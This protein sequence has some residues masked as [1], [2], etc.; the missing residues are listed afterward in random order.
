MMRCR[1]L[2]IVLIVIVCGSIAGWLIGLEI[3]PRISSHVVNSEVSRTTRVARTS[4]EGSSKPR[5]VMLKKI[6]GNQASWVYYQTYLATLPAEVISSHNKRVLFAG[7]K[8]AGVGEHCFEKMLYLDIAFAAQ[9]APKNILEYLVKGATP[10]TKDLVAGALFD[11]WAVNNPSEAIAAVR[12]I[13]NN[14]KRSELL[15]KLALALA[16]SSPKDAM[17][18]YR[19]ADTADSLLLQKIFERCRGRD[20]EW[21]RSEIGRLPAGGEAVLSAVRGLAVNLEKEKMPEM[22]VWANSLGKGPAQQ[23][24][25]S[26]I[27]ASYA[28]REG[29]DFEKLLSKIDDDKLKSDII[30]SLTGAE[31]PKSIARLNQCIDGNLVGEDWSYG[32]LNLLSA[33]DGEADFEV[34][35]EIVNSLPLGRARDQALEKFVD[36]GTN[37]SAGRLHRWL[38]ENGEWE[39]LETGKKDM[40]LN[41]EN[42]LSESYLNTKR[43]AVRSNPAS[44]HVR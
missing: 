12:E 37:V 30:L 26:S 3:S 17:L 35:A 39:N 8:D 41:E 27:A 32:K 22:I 20:L 11:V 2:S 25:L 40:I 28:G 16:T 38:V 15:C 9:E 43:N 34:A 21:A 10:L 44:E 18:I 6:E 23:C 29:E 13:G 31:I 19:E 33:F 1:N 36:L 14:E 24:L 7:L 42:S 4:H 5:R